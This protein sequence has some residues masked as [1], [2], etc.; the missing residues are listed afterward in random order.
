MPRLVTF[1]GP[2]AAGK[3]TVAALVA[4]RRAADGGRVVLVDVDEVAATVQGAG[5]GPLGL[6]PAAHVAHAALVAGWLRTGVDLVVSDGPGFEPEEQQT[7]ADALAPGTDVLRVL[8]DAPVAVTWPRAQADPT[9]GVSREHGF[10]HR[11]HERYRSVVDEIPV[12]LRLDSSRL[13]PDQMADAV[14]AVL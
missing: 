13:N 14:L 7:L 1:T 6:W 4:A 11:L 2:L 9:R 12:D 8:V 5:V 3:S 10:H